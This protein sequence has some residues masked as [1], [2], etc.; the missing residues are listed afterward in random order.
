M[1]RPTGWDVLGLDGDPTPGVVESVQALAREFGDFAHDVESA[2]RS[3]NSF[4]A[5]TAAMQWVGQTAESFKGQYGPLPGRLQKLYTSYSEASDALSAYAPQLQAAQS[6]ADSAL[7]QAQDANVDLQRATTNANTAAA[8]LKTA[9][10]NH[11]ANPNPQA[12]TD[13]QTTHDT[14]QTNLNNAK[15]AM[16]AL[17]KQ[18]NDAYSDRIA[19]AKTCA[20]ALH[21]AQSDGIHN[22]HWWEHLGA[23]LAEWGGKIAEIA[24]DLAPILDVIALAT[25]WIPGVDVITAGLAEADNLIALAGTG[26]EIAGDAMQGHWSDALMG[27]GM[28]GLTFVGGKAFSAIGGKA[29]GSLAGKFGKGVDEGVEDSIGAEARSA[30]GVSK[31]ANG[32]DPVDLVSG[33]MVS[34]ETDLELPGVLPVILRRTYSSGYDTGRLFGPGWSSTLDQRL[35]INEAGIHFAGDDGQ[36]LHYEMPSGNEP[37]LPIRGARWPLTWDHHTDEIRIFDPETGLTRYFP[38]AHYSDEFGQIRDLAAM[39][40]RNSNRTSILR[41]EYGT[42]SGLEHP[43]YHLAIDTVVTE[44]GPRVAGIRLLAGETQNWTTAKR[45]RYDDRGRLTG[46]ID[47]SG[48]PYIYEWDDSNR[49]TAWVDRIGYRYVYEYGSDGR[50]MRSIG[51]GGY[52]SGALEYRD[53]ERCTVLTNSLGQRTTYTYDENGHVSSITD[54]LGNTAFTEYDR[55]G[56]VLSMTD[57]TGS[58]TRYT[59]SENGAA[60]AISDAAG[61]TTTIE[62]DANG[63]PALVIT[64]SGAQWRYRYDAR[65]SLVETVDP[66]GASTRSA[67]DD[68]GALVEIIDPLGGRTLIRNNAAGLPVSVTDANGSV[69]STARDHRGLVLAQT[70]ALGNV[71]DFVWDDEGRLTAVTRPDGGTEA[72]MW[73]ANGALVAHTTATGSTTQYEIGPFGR[74]SARIEP[75]GARYEFVHDTELRLTAVVSPQQSTWNYAYDP[76]GRLVSESDFSD[77]ALSYS[78]DPAGNLVRRAN[79]VGQAVEFSRDVL[80]R[81]VEQR[82]SDG[83][84]TVFEYDAEGGLVRARSADCDLAFAR[85]PLGRPLTESVD[86]QDVTFAYDALGR[87]TSRTTPSGRASQWRYDAMGRPVVLAVGDHEIR[88]DHDRAGRETRRWIGA[89]IALNHE[90]DPVGRLQARRVLSHA[91]QDVAD[92]MRVI[93]EQVWTRR[94]DGVVDSMF[95]TVSGLK[96]L[97]LDSAGRI[98]AVQGSTWSEEYA[99]DPMG[100]VVQAADSRTPD[101]DAVGDREMTGTILRHAGRTHY[102]YDGQGRLAKVTRRLLSGGAKTWT[103]SY[104]ALDQMVEST[105]PDGNRWAYRYDPLGRR[106]AKLRLA[107]DGSTAE[108]IRF[109]WDGTALVEERRVDV[110]SGHAT[111]TTWDHEPESWAPLAQDRRV[112]FANAPQDVV[113]RAFHAIVADQTGTPVELITPDGRTEWHRTANLWGQ[114]TDNGTATC[115]LR[116]PGQYHDEETGLDYNFHRYYDPTTGRYTTPD[117]LGLVPAPNNYAYVGNPLEWIDPLGL[118]KAA[119]TPPSFAVGGDGTVV[120]LNTPSFVN[121]NGVMFPVPEGAYGPLPVKSGKGFMYIGGKGGNGLDPKVTGVRFMDPVTTGKYPHP[122]GYVN[123]MNNQGQTVDR[124]TG[125]TIAK[126]DP[127]GHLDACP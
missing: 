35:S 36:V 85:D 99:Y 117:P 17:T 26:L 9:Q 50:V 61:G 16:A 101:G 74:Q 5:D 14:A 44:A 86:G 69:S 15:V 112:Y 84:L 71:T 120:Q 94:V 113:D 105:T 123:Y 33:E 89:E 53:D 25:S 75:D 72:W 107:S 42:P 38:V 103:Y 40:D 57:Q 11:V 51:N 1:V 124:A 31:C 60:T 49:V 8:D 122:D 54:P 28:L 79:S 27:A 59:L 126:N 63:F 100:N 64:P 2:Y 22:K 65:G 87:K 92:G 102:D 30:N 73:D 83:D 78:L 108:E 45:Y 37:V 7:R 90:W 18:A 97:A 62:Y 91:G 12:V 47:S 118:A 104:D 41:D 109:T 19:A 88:F 52:L 29:L 48:V 56:R 110:V 111:A 115:P 43:G 98:T 96:R 82:T 93:H 23:D 106:V 121:Y 4:G 116:F 34:N 24:N 21:H 114:G 39:T 6:K 10:Q 66:L 20:T 77:R 46:V 58:T 13:A 125:K 67:H 127:A 70:D 119:P 95:D 3:L 32:V 81:V 55:Y 80:G 68:R 76:A